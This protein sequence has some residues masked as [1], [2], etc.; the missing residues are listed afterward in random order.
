MFY[1]PWWVE[2]KHVEPMDIKG[3]P[4]Q[5]SMCRFGPLGRSQN[6]SST[7]MRGWQ[8]VCCR[9]EDV[10]QS[11]GC[12]PLAVPVQVSI[13]NLKASLDFLLKLIM[14]VILQ[15]GNPTPGTYLR[16]LLMCVC[17]ETYM[18]APSSFVHSCTKQPKDINDMDMNWTV[19]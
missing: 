1:D 7:E 10:K 11:T 17:Q 14:W 8:H 18:D 19:Y 12:S 13:I 5:L 2:S 4:W 9:G 6:P 3:R 16:E 15:F